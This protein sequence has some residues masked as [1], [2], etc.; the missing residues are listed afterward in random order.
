MNDGIGPAEAPPSDREA[1]LAGDDKL[2]L[3]LWLRLLTCTHLIERRIRGRLRDAFDT[4]LARFDVLAQLE[5]AADGLSMGELSSRLMVTGGNVTSLIDSLLREGLVTREP[6][7][8]DRRS[9]RV[10]LTPAGRRA[11]DAMLPAHD[12]WIAEITA[13]MSRSDMAQLLDLLGKLKQ[14][15]RRATE[16]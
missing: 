5:R 9:L 16:P 2:E 7:P 1:M 6:H 13:G 15:A 10:R 14:S 3:K 4:T 8:S 11:F 12:K